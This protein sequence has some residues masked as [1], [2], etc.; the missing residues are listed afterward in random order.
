MPNWIAIFCHY[1]AIDLCGAPVL[2]LTI[3]KMQQT[4][5]YFKYPEVEINHHAIFHAID[6]CFFSVQR[7]VQ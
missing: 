3:S 4:D 1:K 5:Q 6:V 2:W 7:N